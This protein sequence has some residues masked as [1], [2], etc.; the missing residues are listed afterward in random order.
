M[1]AWVRIGLCAAVVVGPLVEVRGQ[2]IASPADVAAMALPVA[3][4]A[5]LPDGPNPA[6]ISGDPG[7]AYRVHTARPYHLPSLRAIH[8]SVL[9]AGRSTAVGAVVGK[10]GYDDYGETRLAL[11]AAATRRVSSG[12]QIA[13]G[14]RTHVVHAAPARYPPENAV[15]LDAGWVATID[16]S[17]SVGAAFHS[18]AVTG[19]HARSQPSA[20][21]AG[22]VFHLRTET[23]LSI[24]VV[25]ER[26]FPL[27][28]GFGGQFAPGPHVVFRFGST[29]QPVQL[30]GGFGLTVGKLT[31]DA[32]VVSHSELGLSTAMTV[33]LFVRRS[34]Q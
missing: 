2:L 33:T 16:S 8:A 18:M 11:T 13:A 6:G 24:Q 25:R 14:V 21:A 34:G 4:T 27:S 31:I 10:I 17:L 23:L 30:C 7:T 29:L 32:A 28:Y 5:M 9:R 26:G 22:A 3:L 1:T 12:A 19:S 15:A 20:M